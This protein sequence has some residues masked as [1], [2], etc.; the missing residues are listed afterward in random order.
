M[1]STDQSS[2]PNASEPQ[3]FLDRLRALLGTF[4]P[5]GS[6]R[7]DLV[8]VLDATGTSEEEGEFT[9]SERQML[10]NILHLK[11]V[12]IDDIMV[13][14]A[15]IVA[16]QKD[17]PLGA[18]LIEFAKASH[19]RLVVYDDTLDDPVGMVHIRDLLAF[20]T[21]VQ[22][23]DE[24]EEGHVPDL[25]AVNLTQPLADAGLIRRLL[26][27][28]PSMPAVDLLVSMQAARIHLALV[29]DE[30]GGTDGL[31]SMEDVVEEIVGEIED[32]H[33]DEA[34]LIQQQ[35]D[36]S[37][38]ADART[39]L[40]DVTETVGTDFVPGEAGDEVDTLGG[41]IVT[42]AAR[43]PEPGEVIHLP[44]SYRVEVVEADPRRVKAL[45]IIPPV[46]EAVAAGT[47]GNGM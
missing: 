6:L 36:G 41:L 32:E 33:D 24:P 12:G 15:D 35:P 23:G 8:E 34:A 4:R 39:P 26:Y 21:G 22:P 29:I 18:L 31:V 14:R 44:G 10:R 9:P 2:E 43:V 28:P 16:V 5:H 7:T 47:T 30:Y 38:L 42:L 17:I 11:E 46:P 19:S 27:V 40:E 13:P 25:S 1:S 37:F 20:M 45:R 3:S